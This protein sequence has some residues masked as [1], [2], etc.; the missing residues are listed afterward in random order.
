MSKEDLIINEVQDLTNYEFL[1]Y[2]YETGMRLGK[3]INK[4]QQKYGGPEHFPKN[5][6]DKINRVRKNYAYACSIRKLVSA[7]F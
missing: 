5:V 2:A 7:D 6:Q 1:K 4:Y 3:M